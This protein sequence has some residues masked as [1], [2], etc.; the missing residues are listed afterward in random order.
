M[1][2]WPLPICCVICPT[3]DFRESLRME[4]EQEA[5]TL[6]PAS[7]A[8]KTRLLAIPGGTAKHEEQQ[9]LPTLFGEGYGSYPV[10][11]SSFLASALLHAAMIAI[12]LSSSLWIARHHDELKQQVISL[13]G[14]SE[15]P[16]PISSKKAGGGGGG[17]DRDTS[18]RF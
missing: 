8:S 10:H 5:T 14:I 9:I 1:S 4:L 6:A 18:A 15:Y 17:G 7:H 2:F 16:L 13:V 11:Q 12:I 3:S